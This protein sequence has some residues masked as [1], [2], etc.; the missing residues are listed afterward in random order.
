MQ[1]D[2][3]DRKVH[4]KLITVTKVMLAMM[5]LALNIARNPDSRRNNLD[6]EVCAAKGIETIP[7]DCFS[8]YSWL[9]RCMP[10]ASIY[11]RDRVKTSSMVR[12]Y[13]EFGINLTI[14]FKL[15]VFFEVTYGYR[16]S[17]LNVLTQLSTKTNKS[18]HLCHWHLAITT[19]PTGPLPIRLVI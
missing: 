9:S 3:E 1:I 4:S 12:K 11:R 17:Q 5:V 18:E 8:S 19:T 14:C 6:A 15:F 2:L 16:C 7:A 10:K 13:V